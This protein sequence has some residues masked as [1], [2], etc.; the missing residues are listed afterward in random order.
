MYTRSGEP[1]AVDSQGRVTGGLE[2]RVLL[3]DDGS[4]SYVLSSD[5]KP[6]DRRAQMVI[7]P[8]G[9]PLFVAQDGS[10]LQ[11]DGSKYQGHDGRPVRIIPQKPGGLTTV[12]SKDGEYTVTEQGYVISPD[13]KFRRDP[14]GVQLRL[15]PGERYVA[16][17]DGKSYIVGSDGAVRRGDGRPLQGIDGKQLFIKPDQ[18][19]HI[20]EDGKQYIIEKDGRVREP[21][22]KYVLG[23]DA[24]PVL[25]KNGERLYVRPDGVG[26]VIGSDGRPVLNLQQMKA[27]I[28]Q[29][30][31]EKK[32]SNDEM[33]QLRS[34]LVRSAAENEGLVKSVN[35]L[36]SKYDRM[37]LDM[38]EELRRRDEELRQKASDGS[39][40]R[41][42][43][44]MLRSD[45]E[46]ADDHL[47]EEI[48]RMRGEH[49]RQLKRLKSDHAAKVSVLQGHIRGKENEIQ[50]GE[51]HIDRV[52]A[53]LRSVEGQL[54]DSFQANRM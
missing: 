44:K 36:N 47:N 22:G 24:R 19:L 41:D 7:G 1:F 4:P 8:D 15:A 11:P 45:Q 51:K 3:G 50:A 53:R 38:S 5:M 49:E 32:S 40:A 43:L 20:G 21:T 30:Q 34:D 39:L 33:V 31:R 42:E 54:D 9:K 10:L 18:R 6:A 48:E 28:D 37:V 52:R 13:G 12:P 25:V 46:T 26:T 35:E 17:D 16:G 23:D 27:V 29:L 2:D 14:E